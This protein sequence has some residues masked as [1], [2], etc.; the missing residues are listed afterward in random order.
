MLGNCLVE[1][2]DFNETFAHVAKM[3]TVCTLLTITVVTK[4]PQQQDGHQIDVHN[5]FLCGDLEKDIFMKL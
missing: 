4:W 2:E 1:G 3:V 5:A